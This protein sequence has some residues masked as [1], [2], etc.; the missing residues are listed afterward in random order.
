[1]YIIELT[2]EITRPKALASLKSLE[3]NQFQL[4]LGI[5]YFIYYLGGEVFPPDFFYYI[6]S[7]S[8]IQRTNVRVLP[9]SKYVQLD[10][11][12]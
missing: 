10:H 11:A 7:Y 8:T 4:K 6:S 2:G 5:V 9:A 1:M 3:V 12:L